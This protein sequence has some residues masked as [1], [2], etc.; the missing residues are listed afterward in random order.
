MKPSSL[1]L[2]VVVLLMVVVAVVL[3]VSGDNIRERAV[4]YCDGNNVASVEY[5]SSDSIIRVNSALLG[6]GGTYYSNDGSS[7]TCPVVGPDSMTQDCREV[8]SISDWQKVCEPGLSLPTAKQVELYYYNTEKDR[9]ASGQVLC[10]EKGLQNVSRYVPAGDPKSE[11]DATVAML[12]SGYVNEQEK[13]LGITTEFPL[14]GFSLA[15]STL[16]NGILTLRFSDPQ[17]KSGGGSCRAGVLWAQIQTTAKQFSGVTEV[18]FEPD[19][20]FQP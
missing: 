13:T 11:I 10:S 17:N 8:L 6:G 12:L 16:E 9:D 15:S 1:L 18:K 5:S 14:A 7:Y 3:V 20:L 4:S 19:T 2:L